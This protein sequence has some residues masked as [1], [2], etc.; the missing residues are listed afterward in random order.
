MVGKLRIKKTT[1]LFTKDKLINI[2]NKEGVFD[3]QLMHMALLSCDKTKDNQ[4]YC[5]FD[6]Q[7]KSL[8]II[9]VGL[10]TE[11]MN[12]PS[13]L[14]TCQ[15]AIEMQFMSKHPLL[16]EHI[17]TCRLGNQTPRIILC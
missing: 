11:T 17:D 12:F 13:F 7:A 1:C 4:D 6:H 8:A 10:L 14:V 3:I 9:H 16:G 5:R 15:G 2:T